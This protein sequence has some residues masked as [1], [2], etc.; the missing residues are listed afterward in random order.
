MLDKNAKV[1]ATRPFRIGY[2]KLSPGVD[3]QKPLASMDYA[4]WAEVGGMLVGSLD[5]NT[6]VGISLANGKKIWSL[7]THMQ[8][9]APPKVVGER[10]IL[11]LHDGTVICVEGFTGKKIWE[12][13]LNSF[14]SR[15]MT[16]YQQNV[17]IVT[18]TQTLYSLQ[19]QSGTIN[20]L[21]DGGRPEGI[22]V[23][24]LAAPVVA[25]DKAYFGLASGELQAVELD[26]GKLAWKKNPAF[27]TGGGKFY[28]FVG[29]MS[30]LDQTLLVSRYDGFVGAI[31]L[32]PVKSSETVWSNTGIVGAVTASEYRENTFYVGTMAGK[33]YA[34]NA[35]DGKTEWMVSLNTAVTTLTAGADRLYI[36]SSEGYIV[37]LNHAGELVWYDRVSN[38]ITTAPLYVGQKLFFTTGDKSLYGYKI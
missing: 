5:D 31:S 27:L 10:V 3:Q 7:S 20:W 14:P 23:R 18:A 32:D 9:T 12:Q 19:I 24:S 6:I 22:A 37:A 4:G 28:D 33:V 1:A 2:M 36:T 15:D 25:E 13:S 34:I 16:V 26:G 11:G 29:K 35:K 21:Y 17:L 38:P 30:V 8:L